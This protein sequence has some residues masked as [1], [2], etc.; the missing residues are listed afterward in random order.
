V[1]GDRCHSGRL[2]QPPPPAE[3]GLGVDHRAVWLGHDP[4][5]LDSEPAVHLP[6]PAER[7][8][9]GRLGSPPPPERLSR[10]LIYAHSAASASL[11]GFPH[12][13]PTF[14]LDGSGSKEHLPLDEDRVPFEVRPLQSQELGPPQAAGQRQSP[15]G[16]ET[17]RLGD[18]QEPANLGT[19][20][21]R[22]LYGVVPGWGID[23]KDRIH[24]QVPAPDGISQGL[25]ERGVDVAD[26]LPAEGASC[27]PPGGPQ[28]GI[29]AVQDSA[30]ELL[31]GDLPD[32]GEDPRPNP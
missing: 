30:G 21:R 17:V 19:R 28:G 16:G 6:R 3:Q 27:P 2:H 9:L 12:V 23:G 18:V 8:L 4:L 13:Q 24:R 14:C 31:Q 26:R 5:P 1:Q 10:L 25:G 29:Q 20:P 11:G 22:S 15:H 32:M 7:Q